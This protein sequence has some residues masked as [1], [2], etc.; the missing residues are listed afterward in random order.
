MVKCDNILKIH[1]NNPFVNCILDEI[2]KVSD[3]IK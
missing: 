2:K 3:D 1:K